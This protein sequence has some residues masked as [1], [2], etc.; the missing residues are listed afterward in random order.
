M[1]FLHPMGSVGGDSSSSVTDKCST[2]RN[3]RPE[4]S[5]LLMPK[6]AG[7]SSLPVTYSFSLTRSSVD[8][9]P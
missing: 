5:V 9:F 3:N 8:S 7:R 1:L 2:F 4:V 6:A